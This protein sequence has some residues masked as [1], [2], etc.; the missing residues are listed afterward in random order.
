MKLSL[1]PRLVVRDAP[2]AIAWYVEHLG[3]REVVRH[4][5]RD[6][7]IVHAELALGD[8]RIYLVDEERPWHNHAPA[9]LGGSP[10]LLVLDLDDPDRLGARMERGG[11][12][13]IYPIKD[14]F[15]GERSGRLEDPF[16]HVWMLTKVIEQLSP[17]ELQRRMDAQG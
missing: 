13:V 14:Q 7:K 10:V 4:A 12:K 15:Y 1:I 16:G 11:A 2:R 9:S 8:A 5:A 6:G 17:E 3:A